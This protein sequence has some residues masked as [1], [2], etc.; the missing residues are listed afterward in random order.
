MSWSRKITRLSSIAPLI[1]FRVLFGFMM[2]ISMVRFFLKGWI[3]ELYVDP[4]FYFTFLGFNWVKP[5]GYYGMHALF[6]LTLLGAV[7]IMLGYFYRLSACLFFMCF[8]YI[9]LID[10]TNYLNHYYFVSLMAFLLILVPAHRSFSLDVWRKPHLRL[11]RVP[12]WTILI[13]KAQLVIVYFYAGLAK[14]N[15]DW[16]FA[17][18]PLKLW[19]PALSHLPII[20][21]FFNYE[22]SA[23]LLSWG[24]AIYDL[25]IAFFLLY[26]P[27]RIAAYLTVLFFH[28]MT[29]TLFQI[30]MFPYIMIALTLIFFSDEFHER[31]IHWLNQRV[32]LN[33]L[34]ASEWNQPKLS[35]SLSIFLS[36]Y[37]LMQLLLPL[38][39]LIYP[40]SL[41]WTEQGYRFSWRVML[42]EKAGHAQFIV[43]DTLSKKVEW[44]NNYDYLTP[45]Q[46][47]MMSTQPDMILQFAHFLAATYLDKGFEEP[48]VFCDSRVTLNGRRSAPLI[49]PEIN[50]AMEKRNLKP[51]KW[52]LPRP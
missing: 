18:M 37:F 34:T 8:T 32:G 17:A 2:A 4:G 46:E 30:G 23:Y 21:Q 9:E 29:A 14:L 5:L 33:H 24:G 22:W 6:L 13:F 44:V 41:F 48:Q 7:G 1:T 20:G 35:R 12:Q 40:G 52:I 11:D 39:Y 31:V 25:T 28:L 26:A 47:K 36:F 3:T 42:M 27:T 45:Q 43:K 19:L 38:R 15:P 10:K 51:K 50:L 16:L 49:D